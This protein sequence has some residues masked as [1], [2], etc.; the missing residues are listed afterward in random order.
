LHNNLKRVAQSQNNT[1]TFGPGSVPKS[2]ASKA[3]PQMS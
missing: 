1:I 3:D 2:F